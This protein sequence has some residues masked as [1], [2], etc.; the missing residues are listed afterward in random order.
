MGLKLNGWNRLYVVAAAMWLGGSVLYFYPGYPSDEALRVQT[1][2]LVDS[3]HAAAKTASEDVIR[4]KCRSKLL[5]DKRASL[6]TQDLD[7]AENMLRIASDPNVPL[8]RR[9][10]AIKNSIWLKD[11]VSP[12]ASESVENCFKLNIE[13]PSLIEIALQDVDQ[14]VAMFER[15][16][17]R[18]REQQKSYLTKA[19][20]ISVVPLL[21]IY[22]AGLAVVWI[23]RGFASK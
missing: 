10:K 22:A 23:K 7:D 3:R 18:H 12:S 5:S 1:D 8:E 11:D 21:L 20:V 6:T 16:L 4:Q 15:E 19:L 17:P 13:K 9:S 14:K 2:K